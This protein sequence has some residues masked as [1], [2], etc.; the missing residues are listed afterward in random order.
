MGDIKI[1]AGGGGANPTNPPAPTAAPT[2]APT[3]TQQPSGG[4]RATGAWTGQ[5]S[6]DQW[7]V[8]N[9]AAGYCP[10]THCK[11]GVIATEAPPSGGGCQA[12]GPWTGQ[13]AMNQWCVTNCAVG[14]C[15]ASH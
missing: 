3:T 15:P 14:Y 7:C 1:T 6:M 4:C 13:A 5:A 10:S 11:C 12:A 9:C 2:Q 8:T